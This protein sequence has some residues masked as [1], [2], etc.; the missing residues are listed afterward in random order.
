MLLGVRRRGFGREAARA[1]LDDAEGEGA[2]TLT[3]RPEN[4][5]AL[6]FWRRVMRGADERVVGGDGVRRVRVARG[7]PGA[8]TTYFTNSSIGVTCSVNHPASTVSTRTESTPSS[9]AQQP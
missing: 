2:W 3:V 1:L 9:P 7:E 8:R 5:G 6:V 4:P